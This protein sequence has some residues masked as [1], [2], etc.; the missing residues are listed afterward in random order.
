MNKLIESQ[1]DETWDH[2]ERYVH[3][4]ADLKEM[5]EKCEAFYGDDHDYNNCKKEMCFKFFL[6]YRYLNWC[7]Y[8][9]AMILETAIN[10]E[11]K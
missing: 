2:I 8:I 6:A 5:C 10:K 7:N 9:G 11:K 3:A 4:D 1:I